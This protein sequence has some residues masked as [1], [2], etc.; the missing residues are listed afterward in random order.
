MTGTRPKLEDADA[1]LL[2]ASA[3]EDMEEALSPR[4]L[5]TRLFQLAALVVVV[6]A[7]LLFGPGLGSVRSRISH[8]AAGW[9]A[10]ASVFELLS[11]L[12]YVVVFRAVFCA[13]MSWRLSYQI[14]MAEQAANSLLPAGGAGGLALGVWALRRRGLSPEH[15]GRRT[16]A[17]FLLTSVANVGTLIV[18][19]AL[20]ASGLISGDTSPGLTYAFAAAGLVAT[21]IVL[22]LP[23]LA[24]RRQGT[25]A[26]PTKAGRIR[27]ALHASRAALAGG[28]RDSVSLLRRRSPGVLIGSFGYMGFDIAVLGVCFLAFGYTPNFG[29][30]VVAYLIG[31]LGGLLPLPGGIGGIEGGLIGAFVLYGVPAAPATVAVLTYRVLALWIPAILGSLA[32]VRLR[33]T[34]RQ[35]QDDAAALCEPLAD[36]IHEVRIPARSA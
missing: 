30:L 14:G 6:V 13:R 10:L 36:P 29:V 17:F 23:A 26:P 19:A 9:L 34:L 31:Q 16:V 2:E 15:I 32:F 1:E 35:Q 4:H 12:S 22:A 21:A 28:V 24:A 11:C 18:F 25:D 8:A 33:S 5:R 27:A 20:F 3:D 7:L